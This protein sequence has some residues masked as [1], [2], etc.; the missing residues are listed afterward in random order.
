MLSS[1]GAAAKGKTM[2]TMKEEIER[3]D[4]QTAKENATRCK[5]CGNKL[6][7]HILTGTTGVFQCL[8]NAGIYEPETI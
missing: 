3:L 5:N 2:E 1:S 4:A 8:N 6:G 7:W